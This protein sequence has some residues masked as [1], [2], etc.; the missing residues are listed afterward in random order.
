MWLIYCAPAMHVYMFAS[1]RNA[2]AFGF[3]GDPKG[4]NLPSEFAPWH[5]LGIRVMSGSGDINGANNILAAIGARGYYLA[6]VD[7]NA[8]AK[9]GNIEPG[10]AGS[11]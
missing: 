3:T 8:C 6:Q 11:P 7:N 10:H 1:H 2:S 5:A 9:R 4:A